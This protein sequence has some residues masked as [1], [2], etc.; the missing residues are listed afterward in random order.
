MHA[1]ASTALPTLPASGS[2]ISVANWGAAGYVTLGGRNSRGDDYDFDEENVDFFNV[3]PNYVDISAP[4]SDGIDDR[5]LLSRK[6]ETISFQLYDV[7]QAML[8]LDSAVDITSQVMTWSDP[9]TL[10]KRS[11]AIEINGEGIWYFP[12]CVVSIQNIGGAVG[13]P[14]RTMLDV[15]PINTTALPN[16][17]FS[18]EEY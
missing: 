17:G 8:A 16:G 9:S 2:N 1:T 11:V 6:L 5:I 18:Y 12:S 3:E 7:D 4:L 13:D 10:T 14:V 15:M